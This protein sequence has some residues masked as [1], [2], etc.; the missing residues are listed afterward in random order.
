MPRFQLSFLSIFSWPAHVVSTFVLF[1]S[2]HFLT[3]TLRNILTQVV[4]FSHAPI[5]SASNPS[6]IRY[7]GY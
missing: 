3:D 1:A 7:T 4:W 6:Y 5:T 2:H